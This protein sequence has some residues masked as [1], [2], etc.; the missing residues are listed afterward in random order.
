MSIPSF[1]SDTWAAFRDF[2]SSSS[3]FFSSFILLIASV[4]CAFNSRVLVFNSIVAL[5]TA[6]FASESLSL[7]AASLSAQLASVSSILKFSSAIA[8][9]SSANLVSIAMAS[10]SKAILSSVVY[11]SF[12]AALFLKSDTFN[13]ASADSSLNLRV[14]LVNSY[15][16]FSISIASLLASFTS[17]MY[18]PTKGNFSANFAKDPSNFI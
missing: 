12:C 3:A 14:R 6:I 5:V 7:V 1:I 4:L 15:F 9:L 17:F 18:F 2:T 11:L 13:S 16:A 8:F 10:S